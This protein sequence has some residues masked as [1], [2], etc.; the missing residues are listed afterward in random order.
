MHQS[1]AKTAHCINP[2]CPR[3][4]PQ[5]WGN[6]FCNGCG[7]ALLLDNRYIP[8][9]RLGS[10]G[11]ATIYTVWDL[12]QKLERVLKVLVDNTPKALQLFEQ[13]SVVL[14]RLAH[15]GIPRVEKDSYFLVTLSHQQE[16][17]LPCLVMEK[18][19]G[20]TLEDVLEQHPQGC[21]EAVVRDWLSQAVDILQV[22]HR[23]G[24]IHRDIKPSNL[25]LREGTGQLV[26]IDFGGAKQLG[27]MALGSQSVST[28][29]ISPG[30]SPPEQVTGEAVSPAADFYALGRTMIQLLTGQELVD[31]EDPETGGL[32][33][34]NYVAVSPGLANLLDDM[35]RLDPQQ[36]PANAAQIQ[37]RLVRSAGMKRQVSS[38]PSVAASIPE[39]IAIAV[40]NGLEVLEHALAALGSGVGSVTRFVFRLAIGIVFACLDTTAEMTLGGI[41]AAVGAAVG[42]TLINWTVV[43]DRLAEWLS[44]QLPLIVPEIQITTWRELLMFAI[45]GLGTGW[46]LTLAGGFGQKRRPF[47]AGVMGILGYGIGWSIWQASVSYAPLERLL[48]LTTAVASALLVLGLGLPS[49]YL[50]HALVAALGAGTVFG[51]LAWLG[52]LPS[53]V[54]LSIFSH[55]IASWPAFINSLA[56]FCLL[57]VTLGFCLGVSYYILVPVLRWLGWR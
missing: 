38:A 17:I 33:W 44:Q 39:A 15:P 29:L 31:L 24:I 19:N 6:K 5:P 28:R 35:I 21:S 47:V 18:I 10:G 49:H 12:D 43:G 4:Y 7:T 22:L 56:F 1:V 11:F 37:Q 26:A 57:G 48:S 3:P 53:D 30:Y 27:S 34:R 42:F 36:R 52:I 13:E 2:D 41:G 45:A 46:G 50:V 25:M 54:L 32:R 55:S 9:E 20:Q 16:R 8:I 40:D 14:A 23:V 51:G